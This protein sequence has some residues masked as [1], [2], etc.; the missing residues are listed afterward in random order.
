VYAF[1]IE[2][3]KR[4]SEEVEALMSLA[5]EKLIE[6]SEKGEILDRHGVR[7]NIIGR[8]ELLP[9]D[10]Q[11]VAAKVESMTQHNTNAILNICMPYTSRDEMTTAVQATV[12][13]CRDDF[14]GVEDITE[15]SIDKRLQITARGSP[16]LDILVRTSGTYR[17]SD[18]LLWQ[19]SEDC[20]IHFSKAYW[21]DYGLWDFIPVLLAYQKRD[22]PLPPPKVMGWVLGGTCHVLNMFV[23]YMAVPARTDLDDLGDEWSDLRGEI[24]GFPQGDIDSDSGW[25]IT[26]IL[27]W[28]LFLGSIANVLW[29]FTRF[30]AYHLHMRNAPV[31]SPNAK[32]VKQDLELEVKPDPPLV[33]WFLLLIGRQIR[34][35]WHFLMGTSST[36]DSDD[37]HANVQQL[38]VWAPGEME[39]GLVVA[40]SPVHAMLYSILGWNNW[41]R[42]PVIMV[43]MTAMFHAMVTWY[44]QLIKDRSALAAEVMYEYDHKML[45]ISVLKFVY[46]RINVVRQDACVMT[47][48]AEMVDLYPA[49][50]A[51][52]ANLLARPRQSMAQPRT[53]QQI[54]LERQTQAN[55]SPRTSG[56]RQSTGGVTA[57]GLLRF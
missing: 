26:W 30:R 46:P 55:G 40:Y 29:T 41:M 42:V 49:R 47:N 50:E 28:I 6:M 38:D 4:P 16:P 15:H 35:S 54:Q 23:C 17:L 33:Q 13:D 44:E 12:K 25:G 51:G 39:M 43:T 10:V 8:R 3:F 36:N 34:D 37:R 32:F 52:R 19:A 24:R 57:G 20:Q 9:R 5:K 21:P 18:F 27:G 56:Y 22:V 14:V 1:S 48:E 2:N 53:Y 31:K 45:I 11:K 7:L